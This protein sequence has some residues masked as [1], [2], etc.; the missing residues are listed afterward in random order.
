MSKIRVSGRDVLLATAAILTIVLAIGVPTYIL[1][2]SLPKAE[3][4]Y[5]PGRTV[6][7]KDTGETGTVLERERSGDGYWITV[8]K[9]P[10]V[11]MDATGRPVGKV[12]GDTF[13]FRE[14]ELEPVK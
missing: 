7:V 4:W 13:G 5:E 11:F 6:R 10:E 1:V 12:S 2:S 3:E 9:S 14:F 8:R